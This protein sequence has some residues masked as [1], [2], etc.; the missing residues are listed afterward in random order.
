MDMRFAAELQWLQLHREE[1]IFD[2]RLSCEY[3][4]L[5]KIDVATW[6]NCA[7]TLA[8]L[9]QSAGLFNDGK[10]GEKLLGV[11]I[12]FCSSGDG[13]GMSP[14]LIGK[15]PKGSTILPN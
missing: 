5:D 14:S 9:L 7:L 2:L 4:A 11:P 15:I 10:S 6:G 8:A 12:I 1:T 13:F 3:C